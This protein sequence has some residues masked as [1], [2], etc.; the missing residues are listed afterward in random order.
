MVNRRLKQDACLKEAFVL[1][2]CNRVEMYGVGDLRHCGY[3]ERMKCF[4][5][6]FHNLSPGD[7]ENFFYIYEGGDVVRHLFRVASGLDSMVVGE[8]EILGQLK[9]A[10][11]DARESRTT[12]KILNRLLEKSFNAAKKV[13]TETFIGRGPVSVGSVAVRL[14]AKILGKLS[15][16]KAL[17]FGAGSVAQQ[18]ILYLKK[19]GVGFL[20]LRNRNEQRG[21]RL[22]GIFGVEAVS[23][24]DLPGMLRDVDL[25]VVATGAPHFI[26]YPAEIASAM[27][28]R[29]QRPLFIIDLSVPRNVDPDVN[30]IDNVYVYNIDDLRKIAERNLG[31]RRSEADGCHKIIA[32]TSQGFMDWFFRNAR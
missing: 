8:M 28:Q 23:R 30:H 11:R 20:G 7:A 32:R 4:L 3:P 31:L 25:A 24:N 15:G 22:A 21:N 19:C 29:G 6:A 2:T 27:P 13:R 5:C 1:S 17:V 16:K 10:Y 14:A 26:I 12:G 9:K 18:V